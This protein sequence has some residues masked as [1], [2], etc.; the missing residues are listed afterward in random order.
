[1]TNERKLYYFHIQHDRSEMDKDSPSTIANADEEWRAIEET[2]ES[3]P[4]PRKIYSDSFLFKDRSPREQE[5][6]S[7]GHLICLVLLQP[8]LSDDEKRLLKSQVQMS[9]RVRKD[10]QQAFL[11]QLAEHFVTLP[12]FSNND[13]LLLKL[14][15]KGSSLVACESREIHSE[16]SRCLTAFLE[17]YGS[18]RHTR[19][20]CNILRIMFQRN[21]F[22]AGQINL[23]LKPGEAGVL[24]L[25]HLHNVNGDM[26]ERLD[27]LQVPV[28]EMNECRAPEALR[29]LFGSSYHHRSCHMNT[30]ETN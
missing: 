30:P 20:A 23:T 2:L 1:M 28:E 7:I 6:V 25:G 29:N 11:L 22:I 5:I 13:R 18:E 14:G 26:V 10:P 16:S 9:A 15:S 19:D 24:F 27:S 4:A 17:S 21:E 3:L 12:Y 8:Y